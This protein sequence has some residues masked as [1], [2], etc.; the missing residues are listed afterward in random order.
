MLRK[1]N[2]SIGFFIMAALVE[3][4]ASVEVLVSL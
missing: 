4:A 1:I 2:F 3:D